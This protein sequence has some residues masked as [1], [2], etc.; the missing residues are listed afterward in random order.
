MIRWFIGQYQVEM[1]QAAV[2]EIE[3]FEHFNAFFTRA[4]KADA[5]PL[6]EN[7]QA[8]T[9]PVDGRISQI[10]R[11]DHATMLQAKGRSY[12]LTELLAGDIARVEQFKG[13]SFATI[14]LSPKDYHRIHMPVSGQ[15]T[16]MTQVP[17]RLFS[18]NPATVRAVP[19]LFARNERV[20]C[21]FDTVLGPMALILVGALFVGSMETVWHGQITPPHGGQL[22]YWKYE[23]QDRTLYKGVE[24]GRFNMGST[25]ILLFPENRVQWSE[26][27]AAD[28]SVRMGQYLAGLVS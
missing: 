21:Y 18:V 10:G 15:L 26:Q 11:I 25:V 5:R 3:A 1:K 17:G 28:D 8:I 27:I 14:Y 20:I 23:N 13:G 22:C 24:M 16:Q 6:D 19:R 7:T 4:L 9:S 12:T 2:Q